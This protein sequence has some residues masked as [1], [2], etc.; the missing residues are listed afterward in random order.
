MHGGLELADIFREHGESYRTKHGAHHP[1]HHH[2][3]MR[4][5]EVC[6]TA[7]LGGHIDSCDTCGETRISYNSCRNRHCPKCQC[8][9][10]ERWLEK[11]KE[12]LLPIGYFHVVFTL[13]QELRPIALRNQ[14]IVY[15]ILFKA[16]SQ[17]LIE[18]SKDAKYLG[19]DIGVTAVLHTWSQTLRDHPHVHCLVT[20]GGLSPDQQKWISSR[21]RFFLPERVMAA[22]FRGKF[23]DAL[24]KAYEKEQLTFCG[25]ISPLAFPGAFNGLLSKLY[26]TNWIVHCKAPFGGPGQVLDYLGRYTHRVALSNQRLLRLHNEQVTF[27]YQDRQDDNKRKVMTLSVEEFMRRFLLH[28]LPPGFVK[29][30]HYGLLSTCHRNTKLK[31]AQHLLGADLE[32]TEESDTVSYQELL[33][34]LTGLDLNVCPHCQQGTMIPM[35]AL[36]PRSAHPPTSY[37]RLSA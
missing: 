27:A 34:R 15:N 36:M 11:R 1:L 37:T 35:Q 31:K 25:T 12:D 30:R 23:L 9:P 19:A 13:P 32:K 10:K 22:L 4:A 7:A 26:R 20:G 21:K 28:I 5:I 8:L 6:R 18:L 16:A 3:A 14:E 33:L 24:K 17:T 2:K 29:I